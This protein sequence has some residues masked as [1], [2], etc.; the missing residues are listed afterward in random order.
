MPKGIRKTSSEAGA[1]EETVP[2]IKK[3]TDI[4]TGYTWVENDPYPPEDIALNLAEMWS[5]S[6]PPHQPLRL[7]D[8]WETYTFFLSKVAK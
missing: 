4:N 8:I 2:A 6:H 7:Q 5:R 1:K 3:E